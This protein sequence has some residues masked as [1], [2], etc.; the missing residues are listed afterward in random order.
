M[1]TV[2]L[3]SFPMRK[4]NII[5][6]TVVRELE[7]FINS[8]SGKS[9]NTDF[10]CIA[11][12]I[13]ER[14]LPSFWILFPSIYISRCDTSAEWPGCVPYHNS[15]TLY[16]VPECSLICTCFDTAIFLVILFSTLLQFYGRPF[17]LTK[18]SCFRI[19]LWVNLFW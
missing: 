14:N 8:H 4:Y 10:S 16:P 2:C 17:T 12:Y 11:I 18:M 3:L 5:L 13:Y 15:V 9:W 7:F 1:C 6:G 19:N